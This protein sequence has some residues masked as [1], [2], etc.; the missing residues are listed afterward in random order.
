MVSL[1]CALWNLVFFW[2]EASKDRGARER[3]SSQSLLEQ[4]RKTAEE[5][6]FGEA[7]RHEAVGKQVELLK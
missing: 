2:R 7:S 3:K 6:R 4:Q 5:G 1:G